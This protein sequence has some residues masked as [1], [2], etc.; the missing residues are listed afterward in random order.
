MIVLKTKTKTNIS[1]TR[2][3]IE[4]RLRILDLGGK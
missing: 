3:F 4:L 1:L 2:E